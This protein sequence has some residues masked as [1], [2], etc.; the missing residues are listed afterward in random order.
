MTLFRTTG[1]LVAL[2]L[3]GYVG[4]LNYDLLREAYGSG[5][6][7]FSRTVN[8]DKWSS[9]VPGL[10]IIDVVALLIVAVAVKMFGRRHAERVVLEDEELGRTVATHNDD[11]DET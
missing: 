3:L 4:W 6:P 1:L 5:P 9:P 8:M 2:L 11:D 7:Y 10:L